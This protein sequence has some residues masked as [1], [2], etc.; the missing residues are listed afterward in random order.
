MVSFDGTVEI[1]AND[2]T[3]VLPA[4]GSLWIWRQ[5]ERLTPS[6]VDNVTVTSL[7]LGQTINFGSLSNQ[8]YG[9]T[10]FTISAT[11]TSGLPVSFSILSGP[12]TISGNTITI[13]GVGPV[14]VQASQVG[15]SSYQ[16]APTVYQTLTVLPASVSISLD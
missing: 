5:S 9:N 7:L 8:V 3:P 1:S 13:T 4:V 11:A 2:A 15:N 14:T 16:P 10:P 6:G 12:A